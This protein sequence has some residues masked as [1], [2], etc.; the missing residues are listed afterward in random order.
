MKSGVP[1]VRAIQL[2]IPVVDNEIIRQ[3]LT[4]CHDD[5]IAGKS[6][7]ESLKNCREIPDIM[8]YLITVG[9]ESGSL[10]Q[11]LHDISETYEQEVQESLKIAMTLFEPV[12][13]VVV[14][15]MVGFIIM[16]MLL[17]IFQMDI[18]AR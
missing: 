8:G 18:F 6:F 15:G 2:A 5:L 16:A 13:I 3:E 7:G 17:P 14:G 12:M 4:H 1:I 10:G 11:T 9:E